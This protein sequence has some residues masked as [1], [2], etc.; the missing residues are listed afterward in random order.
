MFSINHLENIYLDADGPEVTVGGSREVWMTSSGGSVAPGGRVQ[1]SSGGRS[2]GPACL[3]EFTLLKCT[4]AKM[5]IPCLLP[6]R[7]W[8]IVCLHHAPS[9]IMIYPPINKNK[10]PAAVQLMVF[11]N[12]RVNWNLLLFIKWFKA[13]R[14]FPFVFSFPG[15]LC[16]IFSLCPC[17]KIIRGC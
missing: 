4:S 13:W 17:L 10:L 8:D 1:L 3:Q 2:L 9:C 5:T 11:T 15:G 7:D 6:F 12:A 14:V 16:Y